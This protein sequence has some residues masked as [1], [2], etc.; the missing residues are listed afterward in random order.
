M[1][2]PFCGTLSLA[3]AALTM[4]AGQYLRVVFGDADAACV[5][6][7]QR[8]VVRSFVSAVLQG[9][10]AE[11]VDARVVGACRVLAET[12]LQEDLASRVHYLSQSAHMYGSS[13]CAPFP[14]LP[15]PVPYQLDMQDPA[16]RPAHSALPDI[17]VAWLTSRWAAEGQESAVSASDCTRVQRML[18]LRG[19]A[20]DSWPLDLRCRVQVED[21]EAMRC[22]EAAHFGLAVAPSSI[23]GG[24]AGLGVFAMRDFPA[25]EVM[26]P[27]YGAIVYR[28]LSKLREVLSSRYA[29]DVLGVL[30]TTQDEF[31]TRTLKVRVDARVWAT[32]AAPVRG[33]AGDWRTH[34]HTGVWVRPAPFCVAGYV[35]DFRWLS[36]VESA[37]VAADGSTEAIGKGRARGRAPVG[38]VP[39]PQAEEEA[40]GGG[41]RTPAFGSRRLSSGGLRPLHRLPQDRVANAMLSQESDPVQSPADLVAPG[42]LA[43]RATTAITAGEEVVVN[44]G[45]EYDVQHCSQLRVRQASGGQTATTPHTFA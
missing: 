22:S 1:V 29:G 38:G 39:G 28:D 18:S 43:I 2:D 7:S 31:S 36:S 9:G 40:S 44:Y 3:T 17:L 34:R 12:A 8:R 14:S 16:G 10:L 20:F 41:P 33:G 37:I 6:A 21:S 11:H 26:A 19:V 13:Y 27:F 30:G 25:G 15:R 32:A 45:S 23:N 35:N 24:A 42:T 5:S 4:R